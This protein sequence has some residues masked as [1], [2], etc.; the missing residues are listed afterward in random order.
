MVVC[1][2]ATEQTNRADLGE[3]EEEEEERNNEAADGRPGSLRSSNPEAPPAAAVVLSFPEKKHDTAEKNQL[4]ST[5]ATP[6]PLPRPFPFPLVAGDAGH[7]APE[8]PCFERGGLM[9]TPSEEVKPAG[10]AEGE[11][12]GDLSERV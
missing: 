2:E 11:D 3:E 4:A 1:L 7:S 6:V 5:R 8:T 9:H 10:K 12:A